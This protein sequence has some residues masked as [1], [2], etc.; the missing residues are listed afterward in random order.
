[1]RKPFTIIAV[2]VGFMVLGFIGR[3]FYMVACISCTYPPIKTYE[4]QGRLNS[5]GSVLQRF[6]LANPGVTYK[7]SR[8][9][10]T[11]ADNGYRDLIVELKHD[12]T[13]ISYG[14]D[15][16]KENNRIKLDLVSAITKA[17][18]FGGYSKNAPGVDALV[19]YFENDFLQRLKKD[20]NVIIKA[21]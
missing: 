18:T 14:F 15:C 11:V 6:A 21:E 16:E 8:R 3:C 7:F 20:D 19:Q 13:T 4:F 17:G 9:D 5:L 12:T 10:S 1:M 2:V